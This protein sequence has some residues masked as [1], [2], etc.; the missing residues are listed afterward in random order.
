MI[1]VFYFSIAGKKV[2]QVVDDLIIG[3]IDASHTP[4]QEKKILKHIQEVAKNGNYPSK[5]YF[6]S[7]FEEPAFKYNSL[8]EIVTYSQKV[9]DFYKRQDLQKSI[10]KAINDTNTTKELV[11]TLEGLVENTER[12]TETEFD[13][14][15][16]QLY[17]SALS[18]PQTKGCVSG[19]PELENLT[20]GWQPGTIASICAFTSHG[21]STFT[22]SALYK[23]AKEGKKCC[24]LSLEM[25]P[26][27]VWLQF[28]ARYLY[29]VKGL[30]IT[31]QDLIHRKLTDEMQK[32]VNSFD[33][34]FM[35]DIGNN[36]VILD[37]SVLNKSIVLNYKSMARL[38]RDLEKMMGGLDLIAWD[39]VGQLELMYPDC[40]NMIIKQIQSLTK[41]YVNNEG[42][43]LVTLFAVQCNREGEKR[44]RKR[45]GVYDIQAISDL[46]EVER[47]SSYIMFMYTSDNMKVVQET[48][49]SMAKNRLG[50][51]MAE[52]VTTSFNP[53]VCIV[54]S[55]VDKITL[56]DEEFGAFGDMSFDDEF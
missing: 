54:G 31:A 7:F 38:F 41:T 34:D 12:T 46:N 55:T 21:K 35:N 17:S 24:L 2:N 8:A 56:S 11:E 44:A 26:E 23:N 52:P 14:Y 15:K 45:D 47:S 30:S 19:V 39:H 22:V 5:D 36:L 27:L 48:K 20:N 33:E 43:K 29:E 50:S 51:V 32:K 4:P 25:A 28:Q 40:G 37:E 1:D 13:T 42:N 9:L 53:A 18:K 3:F 49:I 16:P 10:I 6:L